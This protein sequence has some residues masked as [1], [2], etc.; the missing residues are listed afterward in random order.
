MGERSAVTEVGL[1]P[2]SDAEPVDS[3]ITFLGIDFGLMPPLSRSGS[4]NRE[5]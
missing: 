5:R 3:V 4:A 2:V 1:L